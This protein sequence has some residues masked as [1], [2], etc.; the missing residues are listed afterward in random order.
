MDDELI[1]WLLCAA[2]GR[3]DDDGDHGNDGPDV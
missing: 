3:A 1:D 2:D